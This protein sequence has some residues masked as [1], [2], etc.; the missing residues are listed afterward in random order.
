LSGSA[1]ILLSP[2]GQLFNQRLAER[3][4]KLPH[5]IF[6]CGH[7]EGIDERVRDLAVDMEVSIGDYVLTGGE[8][9]CMAAIDAI[10][11]LIPGVLGD[12]GSAQEE[13][14][15]KGLLEYPQYTRPRVFRDLS[16]PEILLSGNHKEIERW[17]RRQSL[18]RTY[19]NRSDLLAQAELTAADRAYLEELSD[20]ERDEPSDDGGCSPPSSSSIE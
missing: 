6:V 9:A 3:L 12:C 1:V 19:R 15:C 17:R 13:S 10:A 7:Y 2:Q 14:F 11:R 20:T 4:S 5:L 8:L 18:L 16:V